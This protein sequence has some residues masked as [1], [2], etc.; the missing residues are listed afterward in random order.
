MEAL[1]GGMAE[2]AMND[3]GSSNSNIIVIL[4]DNEN[5]HIKNVGGISMF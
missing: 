2:E 5:E 1:T 3:A 4:N